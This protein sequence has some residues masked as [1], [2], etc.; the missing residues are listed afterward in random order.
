M[1]SH[2]IGYCISESDASTITPT[3]VSQDANNRVTAEGCLQDADVKNRNG[4]IYLSKDL[5]SELKSDR[6]VELVTTGNMYGEAGHPIDTNLARQQTID[7]K[8]I[9]P[10]YLKFWTE[11]NKVMAQFQGAKTQYGQ[12]FNDVILDGTKVSFS[13]RALGSVENTQR[14]AEVRNLKVITWDWV[15]YPSHK[16]AYMD[17]ILTENSLLTEGASYQLNEGCIYAPG[18]AKPNKIVLSEGD[19]GIFSPITDDSIIEYIKSESTNLKVMRES[20][21]IC[22]YDISLIDESHVQLNNGRG[23]LFVINLENYISNEIIDYCSNL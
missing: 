3:I 4:R 5:F 12:A 6:T 1:D 14:G 23:S 15:I 8:L 19:T 20:F 21:D 9:A 22:G 11:K 2:T 13:L 7:P 10:K 17:K 18:N 16:T